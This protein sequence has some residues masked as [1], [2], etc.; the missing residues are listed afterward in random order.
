MLYIFRP[1]IFILIT[2]LLNI[3]NISIP[4]KTLY[5]SLIFLILGVILFSI[6]PSWNLLSLQDIYF[7]SAWFDE[8]SLW[9]SY[10]RILVVCTRYLVSFSYSSSSSFFSYKDLFVLNIMFYL[11]LLSV[12]GVFFSR[13]FVFI[14]LFFELSLI[15]ITVIIAKWGVYPDRG[16][17]ALFMLVFTGVFR[18][19]FLVL[20]SWF[21]RALGRF[22]IPINL[23]S[24]GVFNQ[25]WVGFLLFLGFSVKL[26]LFGLH[27]WLPLAH[28]EAPTFGR[29][30][31]AGLLL[32]L[33]GVGLYRSYSFIFLGESRRSLPGFFLR[34][35]IVG[36]ILRGLFCCF[37]S[38]SKRLVAY[39]SV[40]H[41]IILIFL[42]R[43][44]YL[45]SRFTLLMVIYFH[46]L[47]SPLIF[48]LVGVLY[49]IGSSRS[50]LLLRGLRYYIP[51]VILFLA[52]RFLS[53]I[54]VPPTAGFLAEV[55][56]FIQIS[57]VLPINIFIFTCVTF[58][59][60]TL[61]YNIIFGIPII[62]GKSGYSL[63]NSTLS[64]IRNFGMSFMLDFLYLYILSVG[65]L[66]VIFVISTIYA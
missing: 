62:F 32:K 66:I 9:L 5:P 63:N 25:S 57:S 52:F 14:Y 16:S 46:G 59:I 60:I 33:G 53:N 4:W 7:S 27:Y 2:F 15:P 45:C 48:R 24:L 23:Y 40:A 1:A 50:L 28:V 51:L 11:L 39:S 8:F 12:T 42:V 43:N 49:S 19:P 34:Y 64:S 38:D 21:I 41:I 56:F 22:F 47:I 54:P 36:L 29:T 3:F 30:I 61:V 26:P 55:L 35:F 65:S 13:A 6:I 18:F 31:L 37:Q 10:L 44:P 58:I 17:S 20:V